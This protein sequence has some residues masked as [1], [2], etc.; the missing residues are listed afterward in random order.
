MTPSLLLTGAKAADGARTKPRG[1]RSDPADHAFIQVRY[2]CSIYA[3][4]SLTARQQV[5]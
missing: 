4:N 2:L 1:P 3:H 5:C